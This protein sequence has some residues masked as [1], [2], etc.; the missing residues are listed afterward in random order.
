M[1]LA[2][3]GAL[4]GIA[5]MPAAAETRV[6]ALSD[7]DEAAYRAA[8]EALEAGDF[9]AARAAAA[10]AE[11][12]ILVDVVDGVRFASPRYRPSYDDIASWLRRHG[13]LA[14]ADAVY[15]RAI[16][17]RPRRARMAQAPSPRT[18]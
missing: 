8:F 1:A 14:V 13:D 10:R 5:C 9:A 18:R 16:D 4:T 17:I 15:D 12:S 11:D 7:G 6:I 2:A 3:L